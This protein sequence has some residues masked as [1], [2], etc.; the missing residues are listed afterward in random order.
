MYYIYCYKNLTNG[1]VYVGKTNDL[2]KRKNR[3][4]RNAFVEKL[5]LPIYNALRKYS[6]DGFEFIILDQFE[7]EDIIFD[8]EKFWIKIFKSNDRRYGYNITAGGE[9]STGT[10]HNENQIRNNKLRVGTGNGNAKLNDEI[11]ITIYNE[12]KSGTSIKELSIKY[13]VSTL[14]VE[15]LLSGKSWKHIKL[16]ISALFK[17][18]QENKKKARSLRWKR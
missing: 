17:I 16:D 18:K 3:H 11:V 8:L 1:K 13:D 6:E 12:Y 7:C 10:K 9:G 15:R 2:S 4:R 5:T 14:T